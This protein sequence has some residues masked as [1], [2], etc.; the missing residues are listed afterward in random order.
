MGISIILIA[1]ILYVLFKNII[2]FVRFIFFIFI[3]F[4]L[5][6][7]IILG[8]GCSN[9]GNINEKNNTVQVDTLSKNV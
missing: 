3:A 9:M 1:I 2:N 4:I 6:I 8:R 7:G 5:M